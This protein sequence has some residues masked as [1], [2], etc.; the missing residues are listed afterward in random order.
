MKNSTVLKLGD[1]SRSGLHS[2]FQ[3]AAKFCFAGSITGFLLV[4]CLVGCS[5]G[6]NA[7]AEPAAPTAASTKDST[8]FQTEN[9]SGVDAVS[10]G[11]SVD[12]PSGSFSKAANS[13][14]FSTFNVALNRKHAGDLLAE[15]E[16]GES[17]EVA[18]IAEIIQLIRP[19]VLLLNEVD[20]D[21]GNTVKAFQKNFL[22][23]SQNGSD[24]IDYKYVY[25]ESVNTGVDSQ[26]DFNGDG[27]MGT[28]ED[29]FGYGKFPG[30]YG[31]AVLSNYEID[32]ESARTFQKFLWKDMPGGLW[33]VDPQTEKPYYADEVKDVFRLSSKSHW[34]LPITVGD[35]TIHFL[36]CH[37]TPPVFDREEDRN[38]RRNHDEIRFWADYVSGKGDYIYDDKKRKGGL[39]P[40]SLFVIAGDMN[41]DPLDGDSTGGAAELLTKNEWINH[42]FTP[43]S[44][45]GAMYSKT[46]AGA[47][48][49]HQGNPAFDTGD[50]NDLRVGNMRIDYVLPSKILKVTGHGVFW[51]KPDE[52][53]GELVTASDH[54][55]VWVDVEK[56]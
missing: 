37:P 23:K 2:L 39:D 24:P 9:E 55:L 19:D 38:G 29:A 35:K 7:P 26:F 48:E 21:G 18:K 5:V 22:A 27:K 51:P 31:M 50:F 15:L 56:N 43:Q 53:G 14:R 45:G 30:Q 41:A 1:D 16:M 54:R 32:L 17:S 20:F 6:C 36:V 40:D 52:V 28:P 42:S 47:N 33:P 49:S 3:F 25:V 10:Q 44:T 12:K 4:S 34:D 8:T 11:S 46:Q 13:I